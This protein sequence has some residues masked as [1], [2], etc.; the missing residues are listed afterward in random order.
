MF[1]SSIHHYENLT[2]P[3]SE[4]LN[5]TSGCSILQK[6]VFL[7]PNGTQKSFDAPATCSE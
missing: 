3:E 2:G 6:N 5:K 1:L 7:I 4:I